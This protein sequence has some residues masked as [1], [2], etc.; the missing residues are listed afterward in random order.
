MEEI[1][2]HLSIIKDKST[3]DTETQTW[4]DLKQRA[5]SEAKT[6]S[7]GPERTKKQKINPKNTEKHKRKQSVEDDTPQQ[8]KCFVD[9]VRG[10]MNEYAEKETNTNTTKKRRL[11]PKRDRKHFLQRQG[12]SQRLQLCQKDRTV[13]PTKTM[14]KSTYRKNK[15]NHNNNLRMNHFNSLQ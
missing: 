14:K 1:T 11:A 4:K 15:P 8:K 13:A 10:L 5:E 7:Q 6:I 3:R 9:A 12:T 2:T